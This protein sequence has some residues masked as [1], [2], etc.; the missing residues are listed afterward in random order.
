MEQE[1]ALK[2]VSVQ[3]KCSGAGDPVEGS[4]RTESTETILVNFV[5]VCLTP[6]ASFIHT[7]YHCS[8]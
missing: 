4:R 2:C 7:A 6:R 3:R 5:H 1:P 8:P